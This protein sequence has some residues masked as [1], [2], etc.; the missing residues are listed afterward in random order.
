MNVTKSKSEQRAENKS[1]S[2]KS[3]AIS[4]AFVQTA[5]AHIWPLRKQRLLSD[6]LLA[7]GGC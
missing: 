7:V 3:K 1:Y 6:E 4:K 5:A 2:M